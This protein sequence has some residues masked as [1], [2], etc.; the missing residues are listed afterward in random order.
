MIWIIPVLLIIGAIVL[1]VFAMRDR[2]EDNA[3]VGFFGLLSLMA[4]LVM[5]PVLFFTTMAN[6]DGL[7]KW[8]VF[9]SNNVSNYQIA[10]DRT[11]SYLSQEVFTNVLIQGS[12]EKASQSVVASER[13]KEWRDAVN[14]YNL[15][16]AS[17]QYYRKNIWT[18][19]LVPEEVLDMKMMVIR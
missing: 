5:I 19:P 10:I 18:R 14:D 1:W 3:L 8:K 15:T 7:A 12:I 16:I 11:N 17:M 6:G 13:V 2:Y 4:G 9:Y